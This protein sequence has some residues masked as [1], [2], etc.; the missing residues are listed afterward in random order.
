MAS[1]LVPLLKSFEDGQP[2]IRDLEGVGTASPQYP[3]DVNGDLNIT[4]HY[5]R[6][7][8]QLSRSP[9]MERMRDMQ[10]ET[11][12]PEDA[13]LAAIGGCFERRRR[14][15]FRLA[16]SVLHDVDESHEAVADAVLAACNSAGKFRGDSGLEGW[17]HAIV[18]NC[19]RI[20]RRRTVRSIVQYVGAMDEYASH[21]Q[22]I[23]QALVQEE[24][25]RLVR[26]VLRTLPAKFRCVFDLIYFDGLSYHQAAELLGITYPSLKS[27][28][29]DGLR[30]IRNK[31]AAL[32]RPLVE[33]KLRQTFAQVL[34][35]EMSDNPGII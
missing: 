18:L 10:T 24:E 30:L 23:E 17:L 1:E 20:R 22:S 33:R 32:C 12:T 31:H 19:A 11:R 7:G 28:V 25:G 29:A 15:W 9:D 3:L 4:G 26:I 6:N 34:E 5:F 16:Y 27:R 14:K 2:R 13:S 8:V 21:P 35:S